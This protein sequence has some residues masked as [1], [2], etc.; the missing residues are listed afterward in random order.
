MT[1]HQCR[2]KKDVRQKYNYNSIN[3][4]MIVFEFN[5]C[6]SNVEEEV[7]CMLLILRIRTFCI[8]NIETCILRIILFVKIQFEYD[9]FNSI[10]FFFFVFFV[11]LN[12]NIKFRSLLFLKC[13]CSIYYVFLVI[14]TCCQ[15]WFF[16]ADQRKS[17]GDTVKNTIISPNFLVWKFC[18]KAQFPHSFGRMRKLCFSTKFPYHE[19]RW[20]YDIFVVCE[21]R[22]EKKN[23]I[24]NIW[25]PPKKE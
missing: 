18:G 15:A 1:H 24:S 4:S 20:N 8:I 10:F 25:K 5:S 9:V 16:F 17:V 21:L 12:V 19:I 11:F 3:K 7:H 22:I 13:Q 14:E 6:L 23:N 2:R